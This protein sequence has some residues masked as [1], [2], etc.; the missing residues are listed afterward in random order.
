MSVCVH[1]HVVVVGEECLGRFRDGEC[2]ALS[3]VPGVG[4]TLSGSPCL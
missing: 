3:R 4:S 1:V 2:R